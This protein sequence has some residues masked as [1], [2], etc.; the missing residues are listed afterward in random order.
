M[1]K[2]ARAL[3]R[4]IRQ[5]RLFGQ[6][7]QRQCEVGVGGGR[8]WGR[9]SPRHLEHHAV[10]CVNRGPL[11]KTPVPLL[12]E[13]LPWTAWSCGS[14]SKRS[15]PLQRHPLHATALHSGKMARPLRTPCMPEHCM[16]KPLHGKCLPCQN[17]CL[18]KSLA[19]E[20][21][22]MAKSLLCENPCMAKIIACQHG[23]A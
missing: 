1:R 18:G 20:I 17:V 11:S 4:L 10:D 19:C 13:T 23:S 8:R 16:P 21:P 2:G 6:Q 3:A 14:L 12:R 5:Q 7:R 22:C 9:V 15:V